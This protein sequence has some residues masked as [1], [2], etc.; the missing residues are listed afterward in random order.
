MDGPADTTEHPAATERRRIRAATILF[1]AATA[2]SRVAGLL[3]E[4]V[5][6]AIIGA[7]SSYSAFVVANQIPNLLRSLVADSA[8]SG[9][10]VP[11]F[12]DLRE[13]GEQERAW[14][15]AGAVCGILIA[16]LG[17]LT[18]IAMIA[19]PWIVEPFVTTFSAPDKEL[20][21][22]LTRLLLPIVLILALSGVVVGILNTHDRF[23]AAALAPVAWNAVILI[24][25]VIAY[26]E[27]DTG[28]TARIWLLAIGTLVG[29]VV[30]AV[31]P[32]PWLRGLGG[33]LSL[34]VTW[35][36]PRVR[37]IFVLMLPITISLG[38]INVQQ[39]IGTLLAAS[40]D[41]SDLVAGLEAGAGP[42]LL[43]KAFRIYMLPQG[44]F[45]VAVSTV[46]FPV[47]ARMQ[48]RG[49]TRGFAETVDGGLRQILMLLVPSSV[50]VG[51]F[52]EPITR[53]LYQRGQFDAAQTD[54]VALALVAFSIGLT[55]NGLSLLLV[56]SLFSLRAVWLPGIVSAATLVVNLIAL[57]AL[58]EE[59]GV[60]GIALATSIAN[61]V[62]VVLLYAMLRSRTDPLGTRRT[63][64]VG[65]GTLL[66]AVV[67]I[68]IAWLAWLGWT[69]L[70]GTSFLAALGG[71]AAAL[72]VAAPIYL[73]LG[74]QLGVVRRGLLRSLRRRGTS[75]ETP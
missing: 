44:I 11:V 56:R 71:L 40:V 46:V 14:R 70:L 25:L 27:F 74:A 72:A 61:L 15:V 39:F 54:G 32:V 4:I 23:G 21:V 47:L 19:A 24:S 57:L 75:E 43:D 18:V 8:L 35:R 37:E 50:F 55:F 73:A 69:E 58:R 36:D 67:A 17:P 3:R 51:V 2:L 38:L 63:V 59:Y 20:T 13:N 60:F 65:L 34:R 53:V 29:T 52:A 22:G 10:F 5:T 1:S 31:L 28:D 62:G 41:A 66:A 7:T 45:S 68:G 48:A 16:V 49:D 30:Q 33:H 9:A 42:A 26:V 12:S 6:S 64:V